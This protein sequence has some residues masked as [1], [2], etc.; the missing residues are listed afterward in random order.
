MAISLNGIQ[1]RLYN[2]GLNPAKYNLTRKAD[3]LVIVADLQ[4][5]PKYHA[6]D[7]TLC[8][9][10]GLEVKPLIRIP[11]SLKL[12]GTYYEGCQLA[13]KEYNKGLRF[14]DISHYMKLK[15]ELLNGYQ[16]AWSGLDRLRIKRK[17]V[18]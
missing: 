13:L 17:G 1:K 12:G 11:E 16:T 4:G 3:R 10:M 6:T 18:W 15:G 5:C 7:K 8:T 2:R 14:M 9:C